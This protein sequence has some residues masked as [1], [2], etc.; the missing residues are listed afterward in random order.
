MKI[1]TNL[2]VLVGFPAEPTWGK[3]A[4]SDLI[5]MKLLVADH[6]KTK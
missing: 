4:P 5:S 2:E 6:E 1:E 3:V